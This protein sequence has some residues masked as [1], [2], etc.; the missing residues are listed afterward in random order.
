MSRPLRFAFWAAMLVTFAL[1]LMPQPPELPGAPSDKV[2][3]ILAFTVLAL[4]ARVAY[5]R[6]PLLRLL[7][8]LSAYGAL[9]ELGQMIPALHRY[10]EMGDWV[11]DTVAAAATLLV[12]DL[13]RRRRGGGAG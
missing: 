10:A 6:T 11:A 13:W 3:H 8:G 1:A 2:Q 5:P 9:I 7:A 4:L 12:V